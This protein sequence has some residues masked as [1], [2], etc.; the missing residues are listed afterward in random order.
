MPF[1]SGCAR[2]VKPAFF[3]HI[4]IAVHVDEL[5]AWDRVLRSDLGGEAL[6]GG[7]VKKIGF[8]GGQVAYPD[9]GMLELLSWLPGT[10]SKSA[11]KRYVDR[12]GGDATLHH[13]TFLVEDFDAAVERSRALGYEP[14][15]G[16]NSDN[17]K[18]FYL[19]EPALRPAGF[20]IQ[21]LYADKEALANQPGWSDAWE[22]FTAHHVDSLPPARV[23]GVQLGSADL[24]ASARLFV[25][26]LGARV[27]AEGAKARVLSWP[28][29][30]MRLWLVAGD[31]SHVRVLPSGDAGSLTARLA[32]PDRPASAA[33][34]LPATE[35]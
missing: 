18:E 29:S 34:L 8:Q 32:A 27:E 13:V 6:T 2:N 26:V 17:W 31:A 19:R 9:S 21:V 30:T 14:M 10:E 5:G 24:D 12:H 1:G 15:L 28:D 11:M 3:E 4:A 25:D 23:A 33:V 16:R 35:S 20:L 22:P 7:V